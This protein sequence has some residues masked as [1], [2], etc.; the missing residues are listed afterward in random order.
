[1]QRKSE[2]R[3]IETLAE[4]PQRAISEPRS[5]PKAIFNDKR[6]TSSSSSVNS[7]SIWNWKPLKAL[8]NI[9]NRRFD[10]RFTLQV[11]SVH[12]LSSSFNGDALCVRW[13]RNIQELGLCT[14]QVIVS[15]GIAKFDETLEHKCDIYV[16]RSGPH[17]TTKYQ[18][19]QFVLYVS[20]VGKPEI[21]L[22]KHRVD[23][24]RLLP[25]TLEE[26]EEGSSGKWST[27]FKLWGKG[28][29]ACLNVG[30]GFS[31]L[32]NGDLHDSGGRKKIEADGQ[33]TLRKSGSAQFRKRPS[34]ST[35][36][37]P[38]SISE[39]LNGDE[40][41]NV[42]R[43][44]NRVGETRRVL[45]GLFPVDE[46]TLIES[47]KRGKEGDDHMSEI[48]AKEEVE[49]VMVEHGEISVLGDVDVKDWRSDEEDK[50]VDAITNGDDIEERAGEDEDDEDEEK[51]EAQTSENDIAARE[52]PVT[53]YD[54]HW[55]EKKDDDD[56][57]DDLE[58]VDAW[59]KLMDDIEERPGE[60]EDDE[61]EEKIEAQTSENDIAAREVPVT[62]YDR[63]WREKKDDDVDDD[64]IVGRE[65]QKTVSNER[66]EDQRHGD[67]HLDHHDVAADHSDEEIDTFLNQINES[68]GEI[69]FFD[70]DYQE[71]SSSDTDL[72]LHELESAL[73][74]L[75]LSE[76]E[77]N[78]NQSFGEDSYEESNYMDDV[79]ESVTSE[80]LSMLD[81]EDSPIDSNPESPRERLWQ[82]FRSESLLDLESIFDQKLE[83]FDL[84]SFIEDAEAEVFEHESRGRVLEHEEAEALMHE[85][86]FNEDSFRNSP[87]DFSTKN[88]GPLLRTKDGGFLRSMK[89]SLMMQVSSPV[90]VPAEIGSSAMEILGSLASVGIEKLSVQASKLM[91]LEDITGKT[92]QQFAAPSALNE[93][94]FIS[95]WW[96][97]L[98][99][100]IRLYLL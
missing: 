11:H 30:F 58:K 41:I 10:C 15:Q 75:P 86:G 83:D 78:E 97:I 64:D 14:R 51:I 23:L 34:R 38:I 32:G 39:N 19:R 17:H 71:D 96:L 44:D 55:R 93:R 65:E 1:M 26:L 74:K 99:Y 13:K 84:S 37:S 52:V 87:V 22:G 7:S 33:V 43:R 81:L 20:V 9:R 89:P 49:G 8:S 12:G 40:E 35:E 92:I 42:N 73:E 48:S 45:D 4:I 91:P 62:V 70:L 80:F 31:V 57:D 90:V 85:L 21:D 76:S 59:K 46:L 69:S 27:S 47:G 28:K 95:K 100:S 88:V 36:V 67:H 82:E 16:S 5:K 50:K 29:N 68:D 98:Y 25:L 53:V 54:R 2:T 66:V 56:V 72:L 63:H 60:D 77:E 24:T 6:S 94:F 61:D 18:A 79:A 3:K